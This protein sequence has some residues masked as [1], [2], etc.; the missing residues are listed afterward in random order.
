MSLFQIIILLASI[1][2]VGR[3]LVR[4][5]KKQISIW[6]FLLWTALWAGVVVVALYPILINRLADWVGVGRGVDLMIYLALGI[7]VYILFRQQVRLGK[8]EKDLAKIVQV[9]AIDDVLN[10]VAREK[11]REEKI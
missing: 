3:A 11:E 6:L 5:A 9:K 10:A 7:I 2:F 1:G 8:Q 4:C